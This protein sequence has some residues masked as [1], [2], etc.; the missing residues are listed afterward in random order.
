MDGRENAKVCKDEDK[1]I[2]WCV[3]KNRK[4]ERYG[5]EEERERK[6]QIFIEDRQKGEHDD[7][8]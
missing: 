7:I 8:K 5:S 2:T 4:R 6:K 1:R 3:R